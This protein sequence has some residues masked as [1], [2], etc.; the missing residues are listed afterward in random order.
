MD[1]VSLEVMK[2]AFTFVPEEMGQVL[3]RTSYSPNIKERMDA[4][5]AIFDAH[6]RMVAQAEHIPVHLGS[7]P[8]AIRAIRDFL[9]EPLEEGD[10]VILND[11]YRGGS[12]LNDITLIKPVFWKDDLVGYTANKAHHADVGGIAPGS[13][14]TG[15]RTLFEEGV[16]LSPQKFLLRGR[17]D[18]LVQERV[19]KGM[20]DPRE[21][22]GDL[23][24]QVAANNTGDRRFRAYLTK[25]GRPAFEEFAD[26]ILAY[27]ERRV[28]RA[29]RTAPD[30]TY[31]AED[32]LDDD[33]VMDEP[34]PLR[35]RVKL[36]GD[37]VTVDFTGTAEMSAGNVNAPYAVTLASAYYVLRTLTDP[38]APPNQGCYR[39]LRIVAPEDSLLNPRKPAAVAAGN[40]E[41]SQRI[42]DVLL[43]A[44]AEAFPEVVPAQSQGTMNN[45]L[46]GGRR[47][48]GEFAYYETIGGGEGA[49]PFRDGMSGVQTHMTNTLNTPVEALETSY[50]LRVEAYRLRPGS[51]G[52][53]RFRGGMGIV[54][55]VRFLGERGTVSL[56]SDRRRFPPRGIRG[57]SDGTP[58]RNSLLR[59]GTLLPLPSKTTMGIRKDDVIVVETPGGGGWGSP[60]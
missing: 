2:N 53:G 45:L 7:M 58:G 35:V 23:R 37:A 31:D 17:M 57:G 20:R 39:P 15:S 19:R 42:V 5:C 16:V 49:L 33:G 8:L 46:L 51:G 40:V 60:D 52:D 38:T 34:L 3:R 47:G 28:R 14:P 36:V 41:T 13:M 25:Y 54:R 30:G 12:H 18:P 44:F 11:P 59:G 32:Q 21:R 50:P 22:M 9:R 10:Q 48:D 43:K 26:E 29:L 56:I 55:S 27:S 4:S 1:P 24:A 6:G